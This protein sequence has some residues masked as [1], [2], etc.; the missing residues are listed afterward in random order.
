[1]FPLGKQ[2]VCDDAASL[3]RKVIRRAPGLGV[4]LPQTSLRG[5]GPP[6]TYRPQYAD[7]VR[8][9]DFEGSRGISR[10]RSSL[11]LPLFTKPRRRAGRDSAPRGQE[12]LNR[13]QV[14]G[15]RPIRA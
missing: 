3:I 1:M 13:K 6:S 4:A 7:A 8:S 2:Q 12:I 5:A 15:E 11:T 9:R 10:D 14:A